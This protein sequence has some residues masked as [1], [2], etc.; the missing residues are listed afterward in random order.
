MA[1]RKTAVKDKTPTKRQILIYLPPE[2]I[3]ALKIAGVEDKV[4]VSA[5]FEELAKKWLERRR[6]RM[7][8]K[9][10]LG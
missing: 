8:R 4:S 1:S 9:T 2:T 7:D 3:T 10:K 6:T 5:I